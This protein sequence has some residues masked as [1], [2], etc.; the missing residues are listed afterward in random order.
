MSE[1]A[2]L[3]DKTNDNNPQPLKYPVYKPT[4]SGNE[5]KYVN[6]CIDSTWIS[7]KGKFLG[8]FEE[9]FATATG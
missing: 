2:T 7:S 4:L 5:K 8:E 3:M 1:L 6:E 9:K